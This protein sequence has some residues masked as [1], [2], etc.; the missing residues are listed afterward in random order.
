[1]S[2]GG[3]H[4]VGPASRRR[5][6]GRPT[7]LVVPDSFKGTFTA[8]EVADLIEHGLD[9][10]GCDAI[11]APLGDGGEGTADALRS[12][13]GGEFEDFSVTGLLPAQRVLGRVLFLPDRNCA[14]IDT[15]SASG[16]NCVTDPERDAWAATSRGTGELIMAA[17]RRGADEVLLGVGGSGCTDGGQGAIDAIVEGGG[18]RGT[19]LT[20]LC[21]VRTP[22][23]DAPK[24]FGPQKGAD[25]STV[26]ALEARLDAL[27]VSLPRDPRGQELSGAAGGLAGG[28]WARFDAVLTSG[29]EG[30]IRLLGLTELLSGVDFVVTGEGCLDRQTEQGKVIAGVLA[31]TAA[32]DL[33]VHAVVGSTVLTT[34][35]ATRLG[36]ASVQVASTGA[37]IVAA[38]Q[39]IPCL[40]HG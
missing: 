5:V 13:L 11:K 1:M 8:A 3:R 27:A 18:L 25:S 39:R 35:E 40:A 6:V 12:A 29:I 19:R 7:A 17:V 34:P 26:K 36:L 10:S 24:V 23:E 20:V 33:G 21:D 31:I 9:R 28:L 16:L 32:A 14:V 15:A 2:G 38:A 30:V 37:E 22:F 4:L